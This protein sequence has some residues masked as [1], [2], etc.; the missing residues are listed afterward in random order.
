MAQAQTPLQSPSSVQS[1]QAKPSRTE[2][3]PIT[4]RLE[5]T[6]LLGLKNDSVLWTLELPS[7]TSSPPQPVQANN[8]V[9][10]AWGP[11]LRGVRLETGRVTDSHYLPAP[12][13]SLEPAEGGVALEVDYGEGVK[14]RF[15]VKS[16]KLEG[17]TVFLPTLKVTE[18]LEKLASSGLGFNPLTPETNREAAS[19]LERRLM[20]DPLNPFLHLYLGRALQRSGQTAQALEHYRV[21]LSPSVPFFVSIRLARVLDGF[22]YS[23]LA[24]EALSAARANWT[25]LGYSPELAVSSAAMRA[26]G[27]PLGYALE[28]DRSGAN[29]RRDAWFRFLRDLAPRFEGFE[30]VY[31]RYADSLSAQGREGEALEIRA[32]SSS[33]NRGSLYNLGPVALDRARDMA[34]L[35]V[36]SLLLALLLTVVSLGLRYSGQQRKALE[37]MG[38]LFS[39]L[40]LHPLLRLR[41]AAFSYYTFS[42]KLVVL[43]LLVGVGVGLSA[44]GWAVKT[45]SRAADPALNLGT[46]GGPWFYARLER[47]NTDSSAPETALLEGLAAQLDGD[48]TAARARYETQSEITPP[49]AALENNLGVLETMRGDFPAAQQRYRTALSLEPGLDAAGFN[50]RT[51]DNANLGS[52]EIPAQLEPPRLAYPRPTQIYRAVGGPWSQDLAKLFTRPWDALSSVP[53]RLSPPLKSVLIALYL[54][55][56]AFTLLWLLVPRPRVAGLPPRPWLFR[57]LS[58]LVPGLGLIDEVWG[59]LLLIPWCGMMLFGLSKV[60]ILDFTALPFWSSDLSGTWWVLLG[61][62]Y[63]LNLVGIL[64]EEIAH[65]GRLKRLVKAQG[66]EERR[67]SVERRQAEQLSSEGSTPLAAGDSL[68]RG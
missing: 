59:V 37:R 65:A 15:A 47:L 49:L 29:I 30:G 64:L 16:G 26:Y 17:R 6:R 40:W 18:A 45:Q 44:L 7:S 2:Q 36:L 22:G 63:V 21:S 32:F 9:W 35:A 34:R 25:S 31:T 39:S 56:L 54:L 62:L 46:L 53:L 12:I 14:G 33:L 3:I 67:Q 11:I 4:V 20:R 43:T 38:G 27:N 19:I 48:D 10:V 8:T 28:L 24:D 68:E 55:S 52:G 13:S 66:L 60:L 42:E 23:E 57:T 51:G 5:S 41:H 1:S 58:V 50:L 61:F